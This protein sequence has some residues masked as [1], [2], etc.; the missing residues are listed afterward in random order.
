MATRAKR[1]ATRCASASPGPMAG[2]EAVRRR[3]P[4]PH[5]HNRRYR[6]AKAFAVGRPVAD[7]HGELGAITDGRPR[8]GWS[9]VMPANIAHQPPFRRQRRRR[10]RGN[11]VGRGGSGS[12]IV[13]FV[14]VWLSDHCRLA[15]VVL[16][17][18][19][20]IFLVFTIVIIGISR[21]GRDAGE[22]QPSKRAFGNSGTHVGLSRVWIAAGRRHF[23]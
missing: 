9:S 20:L 13:L 15:L 11:A 3:L 18:F 6:A 1:S 22:A 7:R 16:L 23:A 8:L 4:P 21:W 12:A 2:A 17:I 14:L 5:R 10:V 19:I